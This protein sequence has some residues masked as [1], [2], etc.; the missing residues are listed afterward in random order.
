MVFR[1]PQCNVT[2]RKGWKLGRS[3]RSAAAEEE[4][5]NWRKGRSDSDVV[6]EE[7]K[8]QNL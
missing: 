1:I 7:S 4:R 2:L 6:V 5:N 8:E 3:I